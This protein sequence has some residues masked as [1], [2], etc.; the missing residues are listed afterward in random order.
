MQW[1]CLHGG[2][3]APWTSGH[4]KF[5]FVPKRRHTTT[6]PAPTTSEALDVLRAQFALF[7]T[8]VSTI[9]SAAD[10]CAQNVPPTYKPEWPRLAEKIV[11]RLDL[12]PGEKFVAVAMPGEF[13]E[14]IPHL[15]LEVMKA[16]AID[17]GV[18]DVLNEPFPV[19]WDETAMGEALRRSRSGYA[20]LLDGIDASVMLP[21]A[22]WTQPAY[23]G[24]HD[25]LKSGN[26]RTIHFH[27][28]Q[29]GSAFAVDGQPLPRRHVIEDTYQTAVL[30]TD[31]AALRQRQDAFVSAMR[32]ST[33]RV[34]TEV[35]TDISFRIGNRPV[36]IQDGDASRQRTSEA[37]VLVDREI[38][39][40]AGVI[41]VA[42]LEDSVNGTIVFEYSQWSGRVVKNLTLTVEKGIVVSAQAEKGQEA[43]LRELE[44]VGTTSRSFREFAL[45]FNPLLAVPTESP[46]I[47][48]YGYGDGVVRLSLGDNTELGGNVP[49]NYI[50]WNFFADA[51]VYVD[52]VRWVENGRSVR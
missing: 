19:A 17:L 20:E 1:H 28:I 47:A 4:S 29:N 16:G 31:Y 7:A 38:E 34:T 26:G 9:L 21:G 43:V 44:S 15:R 22:S 46:W 6:R 18:I 2:A 8:L 11:D 40:P 32:D 45:G 41:R 24:L 5:K 51:S 37:K 33:V 35:G 48:Y 3:T 12:K 25:T 52:G 49:G 50:R 13:D 36:N 10:V 42:P 39:L 14:L 27:W 30:E 23:L